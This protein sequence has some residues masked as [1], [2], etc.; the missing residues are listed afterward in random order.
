MLR[1]Y[2]G[3]QRTP[4]TEWGTD[5]ETGRQGRLELNPARISCGIAMKLMSLSYP[6]EGGRF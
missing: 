1:V 6:N 4:T 5:T 2:V 3:A